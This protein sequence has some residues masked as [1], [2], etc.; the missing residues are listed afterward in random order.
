MKEKEFK[1]RYSKIWKLHRMR[2]ELLN[3]RV[4]ACNHEAVVASEELRQ[5]Y[6]EENSIYKKG[7]I[8]KDSNGIILRVESISPCDCFGYGEIPNVRY[9]GVLLN[10]SLT[11]RPS[12][13]CGVVFE[14]DVVELIKKA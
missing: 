6:V 4:K 10:D 5:Q 2:I 3:D 9:L 13:N 7:D 14:A 1:E 11:E 12:P 8:I